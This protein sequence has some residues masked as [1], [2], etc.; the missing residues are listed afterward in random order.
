MEVDKDILDE[1]NDKVDLIL[2]FSLKDVDLKQIS[3]KFQF[4]HAA[5]KLEYEFSRTERLHN[6]RIILQRMADLAFDTA[7]I[8]LERSLTLSRNQVEKEGTFS[9]TEAFEF[10]MASRVD[11]VDD[12][13]PSCD[14]ILDCSA[15]L[16]F[17]SVSVLSLVILASKSL[18]YEI[19]IYLLDKKILTY[20]TDALRVPKEHEIRYFLEGHKTEL[21][22]LVANLS[23]E[24]KP[25]S[26]GIAGN[27]ELLISILSSTSIDEEN[28]G[29]GEW[30][31]FAIRNI[32]CISEEART[33]LRKLSPV[34]L[35]SDN[36]RVTTI[37]QN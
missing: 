10:P 24:N 16:S 7:A 33:K 6:L 8:I 3:V 22:R 25:V 9:H 26:V 37:S 11:S 12:F 2:N 5:H 18:R 28:P 4:E 14:S 27:D 32:C 35:D 23:F 13:S 29:I 34:Q 31:K 21:L 15:N 36:E 20:L 30:A 19:Q 17:L 1:L